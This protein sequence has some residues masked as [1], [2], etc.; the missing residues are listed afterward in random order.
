MVDGEIRRLLRIDKL[1]AVLLDA[2]GDHGIVDNRHELDD[3][4]PEHVVKKTAI[5]IEYIHQETSLFDAGGLVLHLPIDACRLLLDRIDMRRQNSNQTMRC[6]FLLCK[7]RPF[8]PKRI[9]QQFIPHFFHRNLHFHIKIHGSSPLI[10][11]TQPIPFL[12]GIFDKRNDSPSLSHDRL[13]NFVFAEGST[14]PHNIR[15][16]TQFYGFFCMIM[17]RYLT[18]II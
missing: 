11:R 17:G 6:P 7:R 10:E 14:S 9:V 12:F 5:P 18:V 3:V 2:L 8:V 16:R 1:F 13:R 15:D 4:L